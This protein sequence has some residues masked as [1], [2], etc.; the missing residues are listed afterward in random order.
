MFVPP[1]FLLVLRLLFLPCGPQQR[2]FLGGLRMIELIPRPAE[3]VAMRG[4]PQAIML[5]A[6]RRVRFR[7]MGPKPASYPACSRTNPPSTVKCRFWPAS[8]RT[9][10]TVAAAVGLLPVRRACSSSSFSTR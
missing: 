7:S 5:E 2:Q 10:K 8:F 6:T 9:V 3:A 4:A 1:L